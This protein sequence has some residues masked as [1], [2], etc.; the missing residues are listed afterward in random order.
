M[1]IFTSFETTIIKNCTFFNN[2]GIYGG[3]ENYILINIGVIYIQNTL[4]YNEVFIT[5]ST[6]DNN[7]G[8][9]GGGNFE[10]YLL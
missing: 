8:D 3:N 9:N 10:L 1:N 7:V 4:N 2:A 6:F 5:E